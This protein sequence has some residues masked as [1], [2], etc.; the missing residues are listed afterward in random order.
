MACG[1]THTAIV[2]LDVVKCKNQV[3]KGWSS[4][5]G[6]GL[7]KL[8]TEGSLTLGWFPTLIGYSL[9]GFG[10]FG[11]YEIFKDVY[12]GIVGE[13]NAQKY[14][15]V[16]WSIAS[17]CAEFFADTLLCPFET[18]KVK[19]QISFGEN[20]YPKTFVPAYN[21]FVTEN[22]TKS[23]YN[24]LP[25]LWARQIPYTIVKFVA[26]EQIVELFYSK[27]FTKTK[28]EYSKGQQ[29]SVTFLSGYLAGVFCALVSHPADTIV[30]KMNAPEYKGKSVGEIY[31]K[32][33]FGGLWAGL[34]TRIIMIGTLTGLQW[35]IYDSFKTAV[36]LQS[37]GGSSTP[38]AAKKH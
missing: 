9:Q 24:I 27:V 13:E 36:G 10:K 25:P 38:V 19:M 28:S 20:A 7:G 31:S 17:G 22:G 37:S 3:T 26:F 30:S 33:G 11:F 14:R 18:I 5:L 35:W 2:P 16:G 29:L 15:R 21:K 12:K 34:L 6:Q 4:N 1:L 32:I 23:L 8:K